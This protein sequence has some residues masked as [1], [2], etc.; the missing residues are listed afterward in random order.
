M[1]KKWYILKDDKSFG[2]YSQE[3]LQ[4]F[5][6]DERI[7]KETL[8]KEVGS[9]TILPLS[10][11]VKVREEEKK[12]SFPKFNTPNFSIPQFDLGKFNVAKLLK[13]TSLAAFVFLATA[14]LVLSKKT[15]VTIS[16]KLHLH[17]DEKSTLESTF[18]EALEKSKH[19][20]SV[21]QSKDFKSLYL[22]TNLP[23]KTFVKIHF[24]SIP[25]KSLSTT[26]IE[27]YARVPIKNFVS[28][29]QTL[30]FI[31]GDRVVKGFY[32]YFIQIETHRWDGPFQKFTFRDFKIKKQYKGE[33][34]LGSE[35]VSE[36]N[37]KLAKFHKL[38]IKQLESADQDIKMKYETLESIT[39]GIISELQNVS[40]SNKTQIETFIKSY[41]RKYGAFFTSFVI[42][43]ESKFRELTK[44]PNKI[45]SQTIN[46]YSDL[47]KI[48]KRLGYLSIEAIDS[49]KSSEQTKLKESF[50]NFDQ[51]VN[52]TQKKRKIISQAPS[53][54]TSL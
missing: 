7:T 31:K 24:K 41:E 22:G 28:K 32:Q 34:A 25:G 10:S 38:K 4:T 13:V 45:N 6:E 21:F 37:D 36:L 33:I 18:Q 42:E 26:P 35:E 20:W 2:P 39:K 16:S 54:K 49:L 12:F 19:T 52:L 5:F 43:N 1:N 3:D 53:S 30:N 46:H 14:F 27:F 29:V 9:S 15:E 47:S 17:Q 23:G 11:F 8:I 40:P 50:E 51:M 44:N 48:A